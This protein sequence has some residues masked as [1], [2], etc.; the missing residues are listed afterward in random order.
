[1]PV[2]IINCKV[3]TTIFIFTRTNNPLKY[4]SS[5]SENAPLDVFHSYSRRPRR[6]LTLRAKK[7]QGLLGAWK[8]SVWLEAWSSLTWSVRLDIWTANLSI[9]DNSL[10]TTTQHYKCY[11]NILTPSLSCSI[12]IYFYRNLVHK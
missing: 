8:F 7:P 5:G 4:I 6:S 10:A 11:S 3:E 2:D 12:F 1:M 9:G